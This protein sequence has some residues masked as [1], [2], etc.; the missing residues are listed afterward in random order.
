MRIRSFF[1]MLMVLAMS[2]LIGACSGRPPNGDQKIP[3]SRDV[4]NLIENYANDYCR[5][6][7]SIKPVVEFS[8][9]LTRDSSFLNFL[10]VI[11]IDV[12][13]TV[14]V[15]FKRTIEMFPM[16]F[17]ST[18]IGPN[19]CSTETI[20]VV[21]RLMEPVHERGSEISDFASDHFIAQVSSALGGLSKHDVDETLINTIPRIP[22]TMD[23]GDFL[24][25]LRYVYLHDV[26]DVVKVAAPYIRTPTPENCYKDISSLSYIHDRDDVLKILLATEYK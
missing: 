16:K 5:T 21:S 19:N 14:R 13:A 9:D 8:F 24:N 17:A 11:G 20:G 22:G 26:L 4:F 18:P 12:N 15:G 25:V 23:C 7:S 3:S 6:I 2:L 1:P 10:N